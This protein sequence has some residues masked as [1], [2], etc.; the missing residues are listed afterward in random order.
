[1]PAVGA[2]AG[3]PVGAAALLVTQKLLEKQLNKLIR[4]RYRVQGSWE[5]PDIAPVDV[6]PKEQ[7][8]EDAPS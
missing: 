7:A 4:V 6:Q 5:Q 3:G 1:L 2:V 8:E